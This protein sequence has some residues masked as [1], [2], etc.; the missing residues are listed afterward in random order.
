VE[1]KYPVQVFNGVCFYRKQRGYYKAGY[2]EMGRR[3]VYMHRYVWE[4]H[5]GPIPPKHH[6]HHID[7]DTGNNT[8]ENLEL[9]LGTTHSRHHAMERIARG[10][11]GTEEDLVKARAAA[12][13]WHISPEGRQW[14]AEHARVVWAG[15]QTSA[16]VCSHCGEEYQGYPQSK[17]R[18]FCS[19]SCQGMARVASG[20]DD[21]SRTCA[22]CEAVFVTNKY[23]KTKTC[24]K[25]CWKEILRRAKTGVR[26]GNKAVR[27]ILRK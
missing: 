11:F 21:E 25:D 4:F 9:V 23:R 7:G 5:N 24:S 13:Q 8:L 10:E 19:M 16:L 20:V 15:Q 14:H 22:V 18:G 26:L 1:T 12:R 2:E 6:V 27:G 17:K 3:T